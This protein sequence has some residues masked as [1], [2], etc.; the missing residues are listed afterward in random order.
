VTAVSPITDEC[1][2]CGYDLRGIDNAHP[3]PEC[4]LLAERSRRVSDELFDTRPRWLR[5]LAT[6][7]ILIPLSMAILVAWPFVYSTFSISVY[8]ISGSLA[9]SMVFW[10]L[11][12]WLG[13]DLA[14]PVFVVGVWLLTVR[15]GYLPADRADADLRRGVRFASLVPIAALILGQS[16]SF[17][18]LRSVYSGTGPPIWARYFGYVVPIVAT[19]GC[20]PL[21]LLLFY[22]LRGLAK[23][24]RSAHLAEHC[25]IVGVGTSLS[26]LYV[27]I[28]WVLL[29]HGNE[30]FGGNWT[31]RSRW[32]LL[33]MVLLATLTFLFA[34]WSL[35]LMIRFGISFR[36]AG[37]LMRWK[38][39]LGDHAGRTTAS[40]IPADSR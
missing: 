13:V 11:V 27:A 9:R 5:S 38:W 20:A 22:R 6:G 34:L 16:Q 24:A 33:I 40:P 8:T 39:R 21:P 25:M 17:F 29:E 35:Y 7:V 23:R 3:C 15:E 31:S 26:L 4:G 28:A 36:R 32:S 2:R 12:P 14:I 1:L 10:A 18:V 19:I 30:W 37:K